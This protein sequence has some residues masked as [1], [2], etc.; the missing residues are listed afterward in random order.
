MH[1]YQDSTQDLDTRID[2]LISRMT[3]LEK[4]R[5]LHYQSPAIPHL[6]VPAYNW[7]NECLHGVAR[8]GKATVFPQAINLAATFDADFVKTV[9]RTI[10]MEARA[11]YARSVLAGQRGQYRG[12]TFWTP[13]I[14]IFRDPRW[15]RGQETYG[16]D[17]F[18]M[19]RMGLAV[20][21]GLQGDDPEKL[22]TAACAK[23]FAVHSGPEEQ[24]HVF[25][26]HPSRQDFRETYLPAFKALV[27]GGVETVMGA[28]NRVYGEPACGS[29]YLLETILRR[30]WKFEGH[31]VS[32][33]WALN[34]FHL[35]HKVTKTSTESAAM[36]LKN[37]C[38]LNCGC[39]YEELPAA[40]QEG[41]ISD[42]DLDRSLR[43]LLRT[44]FRLGMFDETEDGLMEMAACTK[45]AGEENGQLALDA[46]RRSVVLLK[47]QNNILPLPAGGAN[48]FVCG[49]Y[50]TSIDVLLGNYYGM[51]D[52]LTTILEG[53]T[54]QVEDDTNIEYHPAFLP[55]RPKPNK[56]NW[57]IGPARNRN[58]VIAVVGLDPFMEGEEGD[59]ILSDYAGDRRSVD[60]SPTQKEFLLRVAEDGNSP[61][62]I[63][64]CGGSAVSLGELVDKADAIVWAGYPGQAGGRAVAEVL[65]GKTNPAGRLP[66]TVPAGNDQLPPYEDYSMEGR[67]YRFLKDKP[68]FPFGFGL[69]FSAF[70]YED[71]VLDAKEVE[72]GHDLCCEVTVRNTSER[73]G[74]EVVQ[75]YLSV[76]AASVRTPIYQ[77]V[78]FQRV[79][80]PAGTTKKVRLTV[81]ADWMQ[82]T[83]EDGARLFE[84]GSFTLHVGG[85]SPG[86]RS[87][88]LGAPDMLTS[89]FTLVA[90]SDV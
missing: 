57:G 46:A 13:N 8:N 85:A 79:S 40:Y 47:N 9:F 29:E 82:I 80:V 78:D 61:L 75:A 44:R 28:Y 19:S 5:Q 30:E 16:E 25:D 67:T 63:V 42:A 60:L 71:L 50:S 65:F 31:V 77:L 66:F 81:P 36:A 72:A 76:D 88:E 3:P 90:L 1:P 20:V 74:D 55:D 54:G 89:S 43:R 84:A 32:D 87:S 41:M 45:V 34:D 51:N 73:D 38:D 33:C 14:N 86:A 69:G 7:W 26:A 24:R 35:H 18:L 23:H 2:D 56:V 48:Y 59:A 27:E 17:P 4:M 22:L 11:K 64:V 83:R 70:T 37:G 39:V 15:G 68:E 52:R 53:V 49:T 10:A 21:N 58:A 62:V 6:G 12:L